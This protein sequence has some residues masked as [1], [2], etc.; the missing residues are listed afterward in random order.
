VSLLLLGT[1]HWVP[2]SWVGTLATTPCFVGGGMVLKLRWSMCDEFV[3]S[4][5]IVGSPYM[6]S[7]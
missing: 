6:L 4:S 1:F 5:G 7:C 2:S 3:T